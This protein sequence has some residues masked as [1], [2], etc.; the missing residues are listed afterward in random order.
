MAK[1][2]VDE[3]MKSVDEYYNK[4]RKTKKKFLKGEKIGDDNVIKILYGGIYF[5][6]FL[7]HYFITPRYGY[8]K[9]RITYLR[10]LAEELETIHSMVLQFHKDIF[11][12]RL[13]A[14]KQQ[15]SDRKIRRGWDDIKK[16]I[17]LDKDWNKRASRQYGDLIKMREKNPAM[18]LAI[19]GF[20]PLVRNII[21]PQTGY[22]QPSFQK[23]VNENL[24]RFLEISEACVK[25]VAGSQDTSLQGKIA[26]NDK[27]IDV[28]FIISG[29][30]LISVGLGL[31]SIGLSFAH[32]MIK[33][34]LTKNEN[35]NKEFYEEILEKFVQIIHLF[36][37]VFAQMKFFEQ[38]Y[39]YQNNEFYLQGQAEKVF[40][41]WEEI[42]LATDTMKNLRLKIKDRFVKRKVKEVIKEFDK[43]VNEGSVG[44]DTL[45][46]IQTIANEEAAWLHARSQQ[47]PSAYA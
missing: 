21:A 18:P 10:D 47:P 19:A 17:E 5:G 25:Q 16:K 2:M 39:A 14:W 7:R 28:T 26:G 44:Q 29:A 23:E 43:K 37:A 27:V 1:Q 38:S 33:L 22:P 36:K 41:T 42:R 45:Y 11:M 3:W 35:Q 4:V 9:K 30:I 40:D 12:N 6:T 13:E 46:D 15:N 20:G 31:F 32:S 34:F 8:Q 24:E